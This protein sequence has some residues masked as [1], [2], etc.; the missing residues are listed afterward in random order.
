[1]THDSSIHFAFNIDQ[2]YVRF[3]A[4]TLASIFENNKEEHIVAHIIQDGLT[5]IDK[6]ALTDF[7]C[8]YGHEVKF[9]QPDPKVLEGFTIRKFKKRI[10][11]ATYY[12]CLISEI[13]PNDIDKVIYLDCDILV[14]GKIRPF[15]DTDLEGNG[16][17]VVDDM[18]AG[19]LI[20]YEILRYPKEYSYFNAG[21]LLIDLAYW[22][23]HNIS[24]QCVDYYHKNHERIMFNDQDIL[25][26]LFYNSKKTL[27]YKWNMQDAFYRT[28]AQQSFTTEELLNPVI[29]H[30]TNRKPW[31]YD[32][33]HPLKDLF[34]HYQ[35]FTSWKGMHPMNNI[36][37]ILMR[38]FRLLPFQLGLRAPKYKSF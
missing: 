37:N 15:Y 22:R 12:R 28:K 7:A 36:K 35:N 10:T 38:F 24:E 13:L 14:L 11:L 17:G 29:L 1:M 31:D 18:G 2:N 23:K 33:Q 20:R 32:N 19:D 16:V 5:D 26:A 21:V 8:Q 4:V 34:F 9:Y 6:Q 3:C 27:P 25:N 30:F